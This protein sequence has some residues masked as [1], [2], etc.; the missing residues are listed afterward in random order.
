VWQ[1]DDPDHP[2]DTATV[3]IYP[4]AAAADSAREDDSQDVEGIGDKAFT[5]SFAGIWVYEGEKSFFAQWYTFS[6]TDEENLP[7]SKALATAVAGQL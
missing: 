5:V 2:A 1:S 4:N 3:T 7:A 6:G